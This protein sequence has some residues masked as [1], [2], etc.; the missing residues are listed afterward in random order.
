MSK[1]RHVSLKFSP[2][3]YSQCIQSTTHYIFAPH[4]LPECYNIESNRSIHCSTIFDIQIFGSQK[5]HFAQCEIGGEVDRLLPIW[6]FE[7]DGS[8]GWCVS[9]PCQQDGGAE[10]TSPECKEPKSGRQF[11][12]SIVHSL[13]HRMSLQA[14]EVQPW[15]SV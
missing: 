2:S 1:V 3:C 5:D 14:R 13:L 10:D 12:P 4:L 9:I 11:L 8:R 7:L 6:Q 15:K